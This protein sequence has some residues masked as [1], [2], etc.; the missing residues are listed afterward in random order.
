MKIAVA[1]DH[2]GFHMKNSVIEILKRKGIQ[3][4]DLGCDDSEHLVDYP[5]YAAKAVSLIKDGTCSRAI[6]CCDTG[7]G[8][9]IAAN[10]YPSIRAV[11]CSIDHTIERCRA[12]QDINVLCFGEDWGTHTLEAAINAFVN[13]AFDNSVDRHKRRIAK[14][15]RTQHDS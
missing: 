7:H 13:S 5:D 14:I 10:R 1:S 4:V 12:I 11:A 2:R 15:E 3:Y 8:M 9:A 6:L